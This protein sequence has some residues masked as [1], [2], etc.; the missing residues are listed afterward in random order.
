MDGAAVAD[1]VCATTGPHRVYTVIGE[2]VEPWVANGADVQNPWV[3]ALE[4]ACAVADGK[5][6]KVQALAAITTHL[7]YNMGFQYESRMGVA[8]YYSYELN[9]FTLS[10]YLVSAKSSVN[11]YDQAFGVATLG[12]LLGIHSTPM[13]THP[14]GFINTVALVGIGPC[15]NPFYAG[16][17]TTVH[18]MLTGDDDV[19]RSAFGNHMYVFAEGVVFD[20]CAGPALGTQTH[21]QF[22]RSM[23][24]T[25]T[26]DELVMS[27]F[28]PV[29]GV[30]E[31]HPL[32]R[33]YVID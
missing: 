33:K 9:R 6:D 13:F 12:N 3:D 8:S 28:T 5:S 25:S 10:K 18:S 24:D 14:F 30:S 26:W 2:P 21:V 17:Y 29:V 15:N 22:L 7:F 16:P 11:C 32:E 23:I 31:T 4:L 19:L 27:F 1:F 20:A